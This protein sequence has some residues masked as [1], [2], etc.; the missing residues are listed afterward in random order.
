MQCWMALEPASTYLPNHVKVFL[1]GSLLGSH[2]VDQRVDIRLFEPITWLNVDTRL[3]RQV[4]EEVQ[5]VN[6]LQTLTT[7]PGGAHLQT[8]LIKL[9]TYYIYLHLLSFTIIYYDQTT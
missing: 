3:D 8:R 6:H 4:E 5:A 7:P 2:V 1:I 9:Y